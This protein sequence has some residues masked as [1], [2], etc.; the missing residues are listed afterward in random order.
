MLPISI[1]ALHL[2]E[3]EAPDF[4]EAVLHAKAAFRSL[5]KTPQLSVRLERF[6]DDPFL[7]YACLWFALSENVEIRFLVR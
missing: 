1:Q 4:R 3:R 7:L 2:I 6:H 5:R